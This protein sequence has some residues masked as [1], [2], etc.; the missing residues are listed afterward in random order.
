[1]AKRTGAGAVGGVARV[2]PLLTEPVPGG[3]RT[4]DWSM[5]MHLTLLEAQEDRISL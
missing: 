1:M 3:A 2:R 4:A 5:A